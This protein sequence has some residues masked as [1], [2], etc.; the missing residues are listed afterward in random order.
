MEHIPPEFWILVPQSQWCASLPLLKSLNIFSLLKKRER[1]PSRKLPS[2]KAYDTEEP[3]SSRENGCMFDIVSI[4]IMMTNN[5][6]E[7]GIWK[8]SK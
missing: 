3:Y 6:D 1:V 7:L 5:Y 2:T 8:N 4:L